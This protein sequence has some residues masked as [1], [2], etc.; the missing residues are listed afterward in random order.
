MSYEVIVEE[1][2]GVL[3]VQV[4]GDRAVGS[5]SR[6]A[7]SMFRKISIASKE[8]GLHR[9]LVISKI[10]GSLSTMSVFETAASLGEYGIELGWRIALVNLDYPS[11]M[12][13]EFGM[14]VAVNRGTG[15][16]MFDTEKEAMEWLTS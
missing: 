10:T 3:R 7:E 14:T 2:D 9:I 6:N 13:L 11:R 15:I 16:K 1:C 4:S 8:T 12:Q 5:T